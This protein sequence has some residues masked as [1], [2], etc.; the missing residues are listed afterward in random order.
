MDSIPIFCFFFTFYLQFSNKAGT[1]S[2]LIA[3]F[4]EDYE[5]VLQLL[6]GFSFC[7]ENLPP[8]TSAKKPFEKK[9]LEKQ[10]PKKQLQA[11]VS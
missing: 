7:P 11:P 10:A 6:Q 3:Q 9:T 2:N 4:Q 5:R 1:E 8:V